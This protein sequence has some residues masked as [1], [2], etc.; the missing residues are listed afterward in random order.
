MIGGVSL[1]S[2]SSGNSTLIRN[3]DSRIIVDCGING[4][5]FAKALAEAGE[6]TGEI[7]AILI[8][9]EHS[10]HISGLGVILRKFKIPVYLSRKT[11]EKIQL[12]L[13]EFDENL[14]H[15]IEP[16]QDFIIGEQLIKPFSVPHD[17]VETLAFRF[18]TERGDITIMTD[19][20]AVEPAL[21]EKISGSRLIFLESNYDAEMLKS[22]SYP[23]YLK[24]R[25]SN[26]FGHLSNAQ[27]AD[28]LCHLVQRGTEQIVLAHLSQKNNH[29]SIAEL[30][31]VQALQ[32]IEAIKNRDYQLQVGARYK[33]SEWM[34][35]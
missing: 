17:A 33:I 16:N 4:K 2:G 9:H 31:T 5:T 15:I 6:C 23:F 19:V 10:D 34:Q 8:T 27:C 14:I 11:Y 26:G 30:S 25:I 18:L 28:T 22:G 24:K 7:D 32:N 21:L 13:G 20:G 1:R 12:R 35:I 29:P 3:K